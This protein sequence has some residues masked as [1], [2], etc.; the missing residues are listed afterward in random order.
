MPIKAKNMKG[1]TGG[2][3][4]TMAGLTARKI[5]IEAERGVS[6]SELCQIAKDAGE[7]LNLP[8]SWRNILEKLASCWGEQDFAGRILVWPSNDRLCRLTGLS[9]RTVRY[10]LRGLIQDRLIST[11]ESANGKRFPITSE[12]GV[13]DAYGFDLA[14]LYARRGEFGALRAEQDRIRASLRRS[15]DQI[16]VA[17]RGIEEALVALSNEFPGVSTGDLEGKLADLRS[18]TPRRNPKV[19]PESLD[20][21]LGQWTA[22]W[23]EA[24]D[25]FYRAGNPGNDCRHIKADNDPSESCDKG[26]EEKAAEIPVALVL[27]A[28]PAWKSYYA[29]RIVNE[30][31][32]VRAAELLR[33]S[34]GAHPDA[35]KEA[36]GL[37]GS[38]AAAA[39]LFLVLQRYDDDVSSGTNRIANPGGYFRSFVR[40]VAERKINLA[41]ELMAIRRRNE[42]RGIPE[43]RMPLHTQHSRKN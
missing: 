22:L 40:T 16:T 9:E 19:A 3:P 17:R 31:D 30:G 5:T 15:F 26:I 10:V 1:L 32:M 12:T 29:G 2:R 28:C 18:Q 24:E 6:R 39:A 27:D 23:Q 20:A 11:K 33:P 41:L 14:P 25:R 34:L 7:A 36:I 8:C 38:T 4:L 37:V 35:W 13:K 21:V 42:K 43:S